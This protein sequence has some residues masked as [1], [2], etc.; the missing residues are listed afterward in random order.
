MDDPSREVVEYGFSIFT[1][2]RKYD[3][4]WIQAIEQWKCL[5]NRKLVHNA[6]VQ[7]TT[8]KHFPDESIYLVM[9]YLDY[10]ELLALS[11]VSKGW[12]KLSCKDDLW[13]NLLL[14][15]F[16]V[17]PATIKARSGGISSKEI[18]KEMFATL[19][20]VLNRLH[21]EHLRMDRQPLMPLNLYYSLVTVH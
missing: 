21:G 17:S 1:Y 16:S 9:G 2:A 8:V 18:Y 10:A 13:N 12:N 7:Q 5:L 20:F 11:S 6:Q 14:A 3:T 4:E 15:K 19:R